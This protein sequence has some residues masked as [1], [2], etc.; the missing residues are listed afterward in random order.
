MLE[1]AQMAKGSATKMANDVGKTLRKVCDA[2]MSRKRKRAA[3]PNVYWWNDEI[4]Q[5]RTE[6]FRRKRQQTRARSEFLKTQTRNAYREARK[7]M[8][9]AINKSKNNAFMEL[10]AKIDENP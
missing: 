5:L 4:K 1:Q 10:R 8:K 6:C 2:S 9:K 3:C 7:K